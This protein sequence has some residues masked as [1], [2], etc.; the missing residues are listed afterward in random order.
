MWHLKIIITTGVTTPRWWHG[1]FLTWL[2]F[3]RSN[4]NYSLIELLWETARAGSWGKPPPAPQRPI[5]TTLTGKRN[6]FTLTAPPLRYAEATPQQE[7]SLEPT[8]P[9]VDSGDIQPPSIICC[10]M[11]APTLVFPYGDHRRIC[12]TQPLR[13]WDRKRGKGLQEPALGSWWTKFPSAE[14]S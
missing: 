10:F 14:T 5:G 4:N 3:T 13:V 2:P 9:L 12:G 6:G 1:S 11:G 7:V 8:V